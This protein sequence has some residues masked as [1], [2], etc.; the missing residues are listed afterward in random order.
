MTPEPDELHRLLIDT[1]LMLVNMM[2]NNMLNMAIN[3]MSMK[4]LKEMSGMEKTRSTMRMMPGRSTRTSVLIKAVK[5]KAR[6]AS[7]RVRARANRQE[8]KEKV[9]DRPKRGLGQ[10]HKDIK[11][12]PR[13]IARGPS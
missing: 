8:Q 6:R 1:T 10:P 7:T 13:G 9:K 3:R 5:L 11:Y 2:N 12:P 4:M